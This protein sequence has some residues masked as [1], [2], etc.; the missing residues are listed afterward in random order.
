MGN[1]TRRPHT[2][3]HGLLLAVFAMFFALVKETFLIFWRPI[4]ILFCGRS[5]KYKEV[6]FQPDQEEEVNM[7]TDEEISKILVKV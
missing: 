7:L 6:G 2:T 5:W 4:H 3:I 1:K